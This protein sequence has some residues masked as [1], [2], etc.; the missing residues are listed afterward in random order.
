MPLA[1][2]SGGYEIKF[3]QNNSSAV[4]YFSKDGLTWVKIPESSI[5][6]LPPE[7]HSIFFHEWDDSFSVITDQLGLFGYRQPQAALKISSNAFTLEASHSQTLTVA[8]GTG[9]GKIDFATTTSSICSVTSSGV[10]T[11]LRAGNCLITAHKL[12]SGE[13]I[14]VFSNTLSITVRAT[15][16]AIAISV[17][18]AT[19]L[20]CDSV[21]YTF[22]TSSKAVAAGFCPND[23]G[24]SAVLYVRTKTSTGKWIDKKVAS[25]KIDSLGNA[26]FNVSQAISSLPNLHVFVNGVI[27]I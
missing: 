18:S 12:G 21:S 8:G 16:P 23:V 9:N 10:V 26:V 15:T 7:F 11:G 6:F 4:L 19:K 24:K 1:F 25:V 20:S 22:T 13:Y 5:E 27:W 17:V 2:V 3:P 14:D